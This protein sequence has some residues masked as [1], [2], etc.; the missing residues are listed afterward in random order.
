MKELLT[1]DDVLIVP[2]FSTIKSRKDVDLS[3]NGNGFPYITLPVI[4]SNMDTVT[5]SHMA[6]KMIRYGA[7]A[8]LHRF[9]SIESNVEMFLD[10]S[11]YE[12]G[13][14]P[15]YPM[16]SI[17]LGEYELERA[18]ILFNKGAYMFVIDVA[19]GASLAVVEQVKALKEI[20]RDNGSIVVGNFATGDSVKT[21]IEYV[22][23]SVNGIKVG[24]GPGSVCTTRIKT[25]CGAPQLSSILDISNTL[26]KTGLTIIADG[27]MR[28]SGDIAKALGAGAHLVMLGGML[29]GTNESPGELAHEEARDTYSGANV[30][31]LTDSQ[32][33]IGNK[34]FPNRYEIK[35]SFK[36]YRGSASKESYEVQG[37]QASW[38]T[39]EGES[40][41]VLHKG[42]VKDVLQD[43]E[44]GLRSAFSYVGAKNLEE[45][46]NKVEFVKVTNAGHQE[47]LPHG[48]K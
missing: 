39:V 32:L 41:F 20:I 36:K 15:R 6:L 34:N 1:F 47:S 19:N 26:K 11:S 23:L 29:S 30:E 35:K 37:K 24:I 45:F 3:F 12:T 31:F 28:T 8:C 10:S 33:T 14:S 7:Q 40:T 16:V 2:Q 46:H 38:R 4:S 22:G 27:G 43:I 9:Q 21:F 25:G 5:E 13:L 18:K 48:K 42:P 44:G 17:G